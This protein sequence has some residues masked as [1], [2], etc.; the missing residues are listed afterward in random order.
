MFPFGE[1]PKLRGTSCDCFKVDPARSPRMVAKVVCT[2][3]QK[4]FLKKGG[5]GSVGQRCGNGIRPW[6]LAIK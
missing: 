4:V 2:V 6:R 3:K 1:S 5:D